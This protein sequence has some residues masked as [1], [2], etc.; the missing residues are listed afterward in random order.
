VMIQPFNIYWA[1]TDYTCSL[2]ELD[3]L[4]LTSE[5][6]HSASFTEGLYSDTGTH[7]L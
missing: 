5:E 4:I 1:T 7:N 6:S 3:L 2:S